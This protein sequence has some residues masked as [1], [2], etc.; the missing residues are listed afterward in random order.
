MLA[1]KT[2]LVTGS[3]Q[4]IG[5]AAGRAMAAAGARVDEPREVAATGQ[6]RSSSGIEDDGHHGQF[7]R[8]GEAARAGRAGHELSCSA[9]CISACMR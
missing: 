4:G 1:G 7:L 8:Q 3:S 9:S 6:G 2:V 5:L